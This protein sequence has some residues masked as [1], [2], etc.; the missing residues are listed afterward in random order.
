MNATEFTEDKY[1]NSKITDRVIKCAIE[2]HK[3]LGP[4]F[5]ENIYEKALISE[6]KQN[7]LRVEQ[8]LLIPIVY[9]GKNV[10]EHRLDLLVED[11]VIVENKAVK[12]FEDIHQAQILSYLKATNKK[13]GLLINFAK[14]KIDVKRFIL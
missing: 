13:I 14:T 3:I 4:G 8:Q 10:G 9:K 11:E 6:M 2:V 1:P 7:G 12:E 5:V